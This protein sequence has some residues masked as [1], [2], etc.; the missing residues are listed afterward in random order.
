V[1]DEQ[2]VRMGML[3]IAAVILTIGGFSWFLS[4]I[5]INRKATDGSYEQEPH[6]REMLEVLRQIA[7]GGSVLAALILGT[8]AYVLWFGIPDFVLKLAMHLHR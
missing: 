5:L 4:P 3:G 2:K 8:F 1:S 6:V 7:A